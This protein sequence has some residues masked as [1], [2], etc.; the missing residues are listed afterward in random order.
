M[1][2]LVL[3]E[4]LVEVERRAHLSS[5]SL[6]S[7][8]GCKGKSDVGNNGPFEDRVIFIIECFDVPPPGFLKLAGVVTCF[9]V[10]DHTDLDNEAGT[11]ACGIVQ[12]GF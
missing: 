10:I 3:A 9:E 5:S 4:E 1:V 12:A 7:E 8:E 11:P 2:V 6:A